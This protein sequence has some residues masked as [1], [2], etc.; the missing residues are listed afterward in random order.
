MRTEYDEKEI[1]SLPV[2]LFSVKL[3]KKN[4]IFID[5][6]LGKLRFH[7]YHIFAFIHRFIFAIYLMKSYF[8]WYVWSLRVN[9]VLQQLNS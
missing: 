3:P 9:N 4:S 2:I 6:T 1:A 5:R 7:R 8:D